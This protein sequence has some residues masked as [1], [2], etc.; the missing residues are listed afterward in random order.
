MSVSAVGNAEFHESVSE[1]VADVTDGSRLLVGGEKEGDCVPQTVSCV[2]RVWSVWDSREPHHCSEREE[3]EGT[4][5][6]QQQCRVSSACQR[7]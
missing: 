1:V 6:H 4:H 3:G 5:Y 2:Y 7:L